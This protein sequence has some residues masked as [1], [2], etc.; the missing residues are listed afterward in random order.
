MTPEQILKWVKVILQIIEFII[1]NTK[2]KPGELKTLDIRQGIDYTSL[3]DQYKA[4]TPEDNAIVKEHV[5]LV[6]PI[7]GEILFSQL[8]ADSKA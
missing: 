2:P 4:N 7:M 8:E 1:Q 3:L 6:R 5:M